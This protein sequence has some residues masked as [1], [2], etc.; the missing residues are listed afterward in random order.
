MYTMLTC[1]ICHRMFEAAV[2][3]CSIKLGGCG[4]VVPQAKAAEPA[5]IPT[6]T[7]T[8]A[9]TAASTPVE[10]ANAAVD[11]AVKVMNESTHGG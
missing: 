10:Q 2:T 6:K 4:Y 1:P 8:P 5:P 7:S 3:E 9:E 11:A